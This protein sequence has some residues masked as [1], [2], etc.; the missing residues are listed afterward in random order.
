MNRSP[1]T[2]RRINKLIGQTMRQI[3]LAPK[4]SMLREYLVWSLRWLNM[5]RKAFHDGI[6]SSVRTRLELAAL[7]LKWANEAKTEGV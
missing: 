1:F 4:S 6:G 7:N 2:L 3:Q 5:A